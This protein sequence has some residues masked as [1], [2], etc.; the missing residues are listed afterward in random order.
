MIRAFL[1]FRAIFFAFAAYGLILLS[2]LAVVEEP[3]TVVAKYEWA[4]N[5][6][7]GL[8]VLVVVFFGM[9][10]YRAP[11]RILWR[12][13]PQLNEWVF[14]DLNGVWLGETKSNWP[15]IENLRNAA[16]ANESGD[17]DTIERIPLKNTT[18]AIRIQADWFRIR[19]WARTDGVNGTAE[20]LLVK[21]SKNV[22]TRD[23][24][25]S[26]LYEQKTPAPAPTDSDNHPGAAMLEIVPGDQSVLSGEYW[27]RRNWARGMN[28][29][30]LLTLR[31]VS[32][33]SGKKTDDILGLARA[34]NNISG[35]NNSG[36]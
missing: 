1:S 24:E 9:S 4:R 33:R 23:F 14:P 5:V 34:L 10:G 28:T 12:R 27:T 3:S 32:D 25:I 18:I 16:I 36:M 35:P 21:A 7:L 31:Q 22:R 20:S 11:W 8:M 17:L 19:I 30:G 29:A 26:Y 2:I 13:F 15:I 6:A